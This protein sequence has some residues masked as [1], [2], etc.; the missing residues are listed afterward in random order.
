MTKLAASGDDL[1]V[2]DLHTANEIKGQPLL[3]NKIAGQ[4]AIERLGIETFLKSCLSD[5]DAIILTG[6]GT[7]SFT[8]LSLQGLFYRKF[9][10]NT[11][12]TPTTDIVTHPPDYFLPGK[13]VLL[14]S[15]ARSGN[16]P[17][18]KAVVEMADRMCLKC[19]HLIITCDP[20]GALAKFETKHE[21]YLLVLPPESN[22]KGLAMTGS[23][24][25]M[26]LSGVLIANIFDLDRMLSQTD[27]LCRYGS[28]ILEEY[29]LPLKE[30]V[31]QDFKRAV[32]LG[33]GPFYGTAAESHL[34]LQELTDGMVVCKKDTFLGLRHG[35]KAVIHDNT[36]L[37][38]IF[39][40]NEY[41]NQYERD[42]VNAIGKDHNPVFQIG[43]C[44]APFGNMDIDLM[45]SLADKNQ[46]DENLLPVCFILPAQLLGLY[47]SMAL[48]LDPDNPSINKTIS[49][50]VEGVT[51]Y[52][53]L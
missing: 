37:S 51:I 30:I 44:E 48:G 3:W 31:S 46:I 17:E 20:E 25:G 40:N 50:V 21:K 22:D 26:L 15:F 4:I 7:S 36:M 23:Y 28:R 41:V 24:S 16:S 1:P 10:K 47:K 53:L 6:A 18:S 9:G 42:L 5:I 39:S 27:I 19:Y 14:V 35:P 29:S 13:S 49:R 12:V 34:K 11:L 45:I 8:G 32:F 38:Y 52:N 2:E 33:S 43:I